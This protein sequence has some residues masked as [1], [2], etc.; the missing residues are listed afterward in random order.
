MRHDT[1]EFRRPTPKARTRR[2]WYGHGSCRVIA[3]SDR[4]LPPADV[5]DEAI[6][7]FERV[8]AAAKPIPSAHTAIDRQLTMN[9]LATDVAAQL[10]ALDRQREQ[11]ARL[12]GKINDTPFGK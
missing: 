4:E 6:A 8:D 7:G 1:I 2:V 5:I 11:L 10:L 3:D 12:L 9:L